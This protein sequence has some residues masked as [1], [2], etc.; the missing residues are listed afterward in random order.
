MK[1]TLA[2]LAIITLSFSQANANDAVKQGI[3]GVLDCV[4]VAIDAAPGKPR[5]HP[6]AIQVA[7]RACKQSRLELTA[8]MDN[9]G[10]TQEE[11]K[12]I[13]QGVVDNIFDA[14]VIE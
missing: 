11:Q 14:W 4:K 8:A 5:V 6:D 13:I 12:F 3:I 1:T 2:T 10:M 7:I 9:A